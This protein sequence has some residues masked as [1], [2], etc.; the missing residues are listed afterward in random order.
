MLLFSCCCRADN[1]LQLMHL[2]GGFSRLERIDLSFSRITDHGVCCACVHVGMFMCVGGCV[3]LTSCVG[4]ALLRGVPLRCLNLHDC[5]LVRGPLLCVSVVFRLHSLL[6]CILIPG[7]SMRFAHLS[8]RDGFPPFSNSLLLSIT[9][10][11]FINRVGGRCLF[12]VVSHHRIHGIFCTDHGHGSL[13][14]VCAHSR[15]AAVGRLRFDC[16]WRSSGRRFPSCAI[17]SA[18]FVYLCA[19]GCPIALFACP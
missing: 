14:A 12:S 18:P 7:W 4:L 5:G 2:I 15:A 9:H 19:P 11:V 8:A 16:A 17:R 3:V 1:Q 13:F 10:C 6:V